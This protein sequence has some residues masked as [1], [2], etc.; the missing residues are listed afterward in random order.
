MDFTL[1]TLVVLV[2]FLGSLTRSTFGFG[3]S[4]VSMPLLALLPLPINTAISL[5]GLTGFSVGLMAIFSAWKY[6]DKRILLLLLSSTMIG[7]PIGLY[8]VIEVP[9]ENVT[10]ILGVFL[11]IYGIYSLIKQRYHLELPE[12]WKGSQ[13][14]PLPF[15]LLS[16]ALGS[17][18]NMN[19]IPIVVYGTFRD[20]EM[21]TFHSTL[22]SHFIVSSLF[23]VLG[24]ALGGL[25]TRDL[26]V[27]YLASL[28][29]IYLAHRIGKSIRLRIPI[30]RFEKLLYL[31]ILLLG[32]ILLLSVA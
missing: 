21:K 24:Q 19:G 14:L 30:H 29:V 8:L 28:P 27:F 32:I 15:G 2:V 9:Q 12:R 4:V 13:L 6:I 5:I 7:I 16:G 20:L 26:F 25:W 11:I 18:Y 3:D 23:I 10:Q 1:I 31:F 22:Q 17:A